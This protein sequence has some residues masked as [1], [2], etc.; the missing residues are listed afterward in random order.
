MYPDQVAGRLLSAGLGGDGRGRS[1]AGDRHAVLRP[2][3]LHHDLGAARTQRGPRDA[4]PLLRDRVGDR[5]RGTTAPS[6]RTWATRCSRCS[7]RHCPMPI[8][9]STRPIGLRSS[10]E[11]ARLT[12]TLLEH[13]LR[14]LTYGIGVN[15][16]PAVAAR[17]G[18][19]L[20]RR[21]YTVLG[22]SV[23][24]GVHSVPGGSQRRGHL[25][26]RRSRAD[27]LARDGEHGTTRYEGR[28]ARTS[29]RRRLHAGRC[30]SR[31]PLTVRDS[32]VGPALELVRD[33]CHHAI[34]EREPVAPELDPTRY[35]S[36]S[37]VPGVI[38]TSPE[39]SSLHSNERR[40]GTRRRGRPS[41]IRPRSP[42]G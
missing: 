31:G 37:G 6:W 5:D 39:K 27:G 38:S 40:P 10:M 18:S 16:G 32:S 23:N 15:T 21:E 20:P 9:R 34:C 7:A 1:A 3:R 35:P 8:A 17:A 4:R 29:W 33:G 36:L 2:A 11:R 42:R 30:R 24:I 13:R 25:R 22:D 41:W 12:T 26:R 19:G 28:H 14:E